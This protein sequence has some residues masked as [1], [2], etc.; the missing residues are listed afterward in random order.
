MLQGTGVGFLQYLYRESR[1][2]APLRFPPYND[3]LEKRL[4]HA[5]DKKHDLLCG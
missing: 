2:H 1:L 5:I 3:G 4:E